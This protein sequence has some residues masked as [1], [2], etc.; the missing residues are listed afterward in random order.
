MIRNRQELRDEIF[1]V[2]ASNFDAL[3]IEIF[4]YQFLNNPLYQKY[5]QTLYHGKKLEPKSIT[6]IPFLPVEFF[7]SNEIKTGDWNPDRTFMSSSTGGVPSAHKVRDIALYHESF[8]K[9]FQ[10]FYGNPAHYAILGLLPSYLEREGSSLIYMLSELMRD[11]QNPDSGFYLYNYFE[12]AQ[13]L[14]HREQQNIPTI[15]FGVTF[16]LLDFARNFTL[17]LPNTIIIE[18][19]GMKGRGKEPIREEVHQILKQNLGA[20][21]VHSEYGMTELLSQAYMLKGMSFN[22]PNWMKALVRDQHDP[23]SVNEQGKGLFNFIDL[24]NLDS[25]CFLATKDM[26]EVFTNNTFSVLGRADYSEQRGCN[27]MVAEIFHT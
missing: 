16:G 5:C 21:Q 15:L 19:G 27:L 2:S 8:T 10:L 9:C 25:C 23:L 7:K 11:S 13:T 14:T 6:E 24:A 18:T 26:G 17:N 3:A 1:D 4:H 12:L 20:K 22:L